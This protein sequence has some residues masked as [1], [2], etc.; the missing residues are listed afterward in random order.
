MCSG[1]FQYFFESLGAAFKTLE[2]A[3]GACFGAYLPMVHA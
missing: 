1:V 3:M 2:A